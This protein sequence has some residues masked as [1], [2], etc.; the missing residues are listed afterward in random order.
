MTE[1]KINE[2]EKGNLNSEFS[3]SPPRKK[4]KFL[5]RDWHKKIKLG[6]TIKKKRKWRAPK[7]RDNKM[8][9]REKGYPRVPSIGWGSDKKT[10]GLINGMRAIR[11]ENAKQLEKLKEGDGVIIGKVGKKKRQEL[12]KL[13]EKMKIKILNKYKTIESEIK[14]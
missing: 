5:R 1:E 12:I 6:K 7:G 3:L 14:G 9:L 13:A 11:V 2:E 10:R 8:R 4:P